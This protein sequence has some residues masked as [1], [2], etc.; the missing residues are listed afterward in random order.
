MKEGKGNRIL[1]TIVAIAT[2]LV[3]VVGATFAY[4]TAVLTGEENKTT[5]KVISGSIGIE[6]PESSII[7]VA[8]TYPQAGVIAT[9]DFSLKTTN[10]IPGS[11]VYYSASVVI[12]E[13]TFTAGDLK[14]TF[15]KDASSS[16]NGNTLTEVTVQTEIP[17][18]GAIALGTTG[19]FVGDTD[20][21]VTHTYHF[22]I[23]FP[24]NGENQN[25]SQ[26]KIFGAHLEISEP[27]P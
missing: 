4:F 2:L 6:M 13:N 1:L 23:Y 8:N 9:K 3:A 10:D 16:T 25:E 21:E 11:T 15:I 7:T 14:Y 17:T 20:G 24:D 12:D 18:S 19:S 22:N 26:E 5:V 27:A